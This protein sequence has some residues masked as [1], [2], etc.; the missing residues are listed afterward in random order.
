MKNSVKY[1]LAYGFLATVLVY[2]W[3]KNRFTY[4]KLNGQKKSKN[5][6]NNILFIGDS[7]T[8]IDFK[9]QPTGTYPL[10]I[11]KD[12]PDLI[13][14][15]HAEVGKTT[16]WMLSNLPLYLNKPYNKVF[17][18]G[19]V[20]DA[21]STVKLETA[22]ANVQKMVDLAVANG[23]KAYVITGYEPNGFMDYRKMPT[24]RY[25]TSKQAYIPLIERYKQFQSLIQS[26]IKNAT[27]IPKFDLAGMTNDGTHPTGT[28][29]KQIAE[30][31]KRYL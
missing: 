21:F 9:G 24:T 7:L 22:V 3:S 5:K 26:R 16:G 10:K 11:R 17:I 1:V 20:N 2:I 29:Q 27:I 6:N 31:I 15:V 30:T 28:G 12:R 14:D 13:V 23:A 19:G 4:L 8:D 18:Y 25:V